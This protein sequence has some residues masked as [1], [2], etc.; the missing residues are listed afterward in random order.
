MSHELAVWGCEGEGRRGFILATLRVETRAPLGS[1]G[2]SLPPGGGRSPVLG[3][4]RVSPHLSV[5]AIKGHNGP[6]EE[7]GQVEIVL[8]Q[9][10]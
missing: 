2:R 6:E 1:E 7:E 10:S 9:V 8:E 3:A 5:E 4:H